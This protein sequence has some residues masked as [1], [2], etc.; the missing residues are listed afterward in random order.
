MVGSGGGWGGGEGATASD[1]SGPQR[2]WSWF[3]GCSASFS[4]KESYENRPTSW[5][6]YAQD[7][8]EL[9]VRCTSISWR[10]SPSKSAQNTRTEF[11]SGATL[12]LSVS[13]PCNRV[14][15]PHKA[16]LNTTGTEPSAASIISGG[17]LASPPRLQ[18]TTSCASIAAAS[19]TL[20]CS[21]AGPVPH[22]S[23]TALSALATT[24]TEPCVAVTVAAPAAARPSFSNPTFCPVSP[25]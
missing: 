18:N 6:R 9:A 10:P 22:H 21:I 1:N 20:W 16:P 4:Q 2:Q 12:P 13:E 14:K 17:E 7:P 8:F 11:G 19:A 3:S 23:S 25:G 15:F 24:N 5:Q